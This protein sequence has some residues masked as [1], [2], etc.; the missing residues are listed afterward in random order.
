MLIGQV[1]A[2]FC[3]FLGVLLGVG[4]KLLFF[5]DLRPVEYE[6]MFERLWIFLTE[7]LLALTIFRDDFSVSFIALY[8]MLVFLKCFHWISADRVDYIDQVPPPGPPTWFHVRLATV[9]VILT[10]LD[11]VLFLYAMEHVMFMGVSAMVLFASEFAILIAAISGT[12]ARYGVGVMDL[13][14]A[15]GRADAPPWEEKS[16]YLFYIDLAVGMSAPTFDSAVNSLLTV[17]FAKLLTYLVFFIVIFLNYGLPVHILRDVYMTLRSFLARGTDLVRYRRATRNMDELYPDATAAEL[18]RLGDHTCIIC[19]E[20]MVARELAQPTSEG[21]NE[22]P[23]KLACGHVFH[24]HCLRSWLERQQICPTCRR[25]VL[26]P[27]RHPPPQN[28][29]NAAAQAAVL[30]QQAA[31]GERNAVVDANGNGQRAGGDGNG[32]EQG[33]HDRMRAVFEEYFRLPGVNGDAPAHVPQRNDARGDVSQEAGT[34]VGNAS[35]AQSEDNEE[36]RLQRGIWGAPIVPGRFLPRAMGAAPR[37]RWPEAGP[38]RRANLG[39]SGN[40]TPA[41]SQA[42][43]VFSSTGSPRGQATPEHDDI[44][45][46]DQ[47]E[48][49]FND[50]VNLR[51]VAAQAALRRLGAAGAS[52]SA[53]KAV[54]D[55]EEGTAGAGPIAKGKGKAHPDAFD[56]PATH[57]VYLSPHNLPPPHTGAPRTADAARHALD[58]RLEALR[59]VDHVVWSLVGELSRLRSAWEVEDANVQPQSQ[60]QAGRPPFQPQSQAQAH[61]RG[62]SPPQSRERAPAQSQAQAYA[63]FHGQAHAQSQAQAY[64]Q[65]HAQ[66]RAGE[67][68]GWREAREAGDRGVR[69]VGYVEEHEGDVGVDSGVGERNEVATGAEA[70]GPGDVAAPLASVARSASPAHAPLFP[71]PH[72]PS[73][74][75]APLFS[76]PANTATGHPSRVDENAGASSDREIGKGEGSATVSTE[77]THTS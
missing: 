26:A 23:K 5:G 49:A 71:S 31:Q 73:P 65:A 4:F 33:E 42:P 77:H 52:T 22:T 11:F 21:P 13:Q 44:V 8:S 28:A 74:A 59:D 16:M 34:G 30:A 43:V 51:E 6:H 61:A 60:A 10:T 29:P 17:D 68:S 63:Q 24:F 62:R 75:P 38:S 48:A 19:R 39:V 12:W 2:N 67:M 55:A 3:L 27:N 66:K 1:L 32:E 57:P 47:H 70:E 50:D 14:R 45:D 56:A 15:R 46:A 7:S 25:D 35:A 40:V 76:S 18:D 20:E 37:W 36:Q 64:A 41:T 69:H 58:Q 72:T 54:F 53:S 9:L